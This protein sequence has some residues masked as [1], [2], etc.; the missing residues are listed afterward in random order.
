MTQSIVPG[1]QGLRQ[2]PIERHPLFH[3]SPARRSARIITGIVTFAL[4]KPLKPDQAQDILLSTALKC[5]GAPGLV[6][7]APDFGQ[8]RIVKVLAGRPP[9]DTINPALTPRR[10]RR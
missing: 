8:T 9:R 2:A 6:R 5:Q 4:P 7:K 10:I 1:P 3:S